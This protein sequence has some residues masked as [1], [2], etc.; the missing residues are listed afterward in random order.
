LERR[1]L[2]ATGPDVSVIGVGCSRLGGVFA[3]GNTPRNEADLIRAAIDAGINFFD[4]SDMYSHGQSEI[5]VGRAV[6]SRRSEVILATK[7]GY[8]R[9]R[10]VRL[11]ARAKPLMRPVVRAL[12]VKRPHGASSGTG[13]LGQDFSP[14]HL[15]RA[16]EA[17]LRRLR[18]DYIDVYQLHSPPAEV[19]E[20]GDYVPVLERLRDQGKIIRYGIAGAEAADMVAFDRHPSVSTLQL[21]FSLIDQRASQVI[22]PKATATGV[23]VISRSCFAAGLLTGSLSEDDLRARTPD[24]AAIVAFRSKAQIVGRPVRELAL[25]FNLSTEPIAVTIVG[26]SRPAHL[27][28]ILQDAVAPPLSPQERAV[29]VE[30]SQ[31]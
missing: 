20:A 3:A 8:V 5:L 9:P 22:F 31:A 26:M 23:G 28:Q 7:G 30:P 6:R 4:T 17:S 19:V 11:L 13:S 14:A 29:L 18:T 2:G 24:W 16:V 1:P 25:Q 12:G 15:A 10:Q 27:K 21:P